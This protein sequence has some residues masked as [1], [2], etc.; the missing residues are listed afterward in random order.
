MFSSMH[1][2]TGVALLF[3]SLTLGLIA[4]ENDEFQEKGK[5]KGKGKGKSEIVQVDLSKLHPGIAQYIRDQIGQ[6]YKG[7]DEM[8]K[9]K[10]KG[11]GEAK[12]TPEPEPKKKAESKGKG[13]GKLISLADAISIGERSGTVIKA[14]RRGEAADATFK[15]EVL[16]S[17]GA[18]T[19][20]SLDANGRVI[21]DAQKKGDEKGKK[22]KGKGNQDG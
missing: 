18:K 7:K 22:G 14:E 1:R 9:G 10:G 4:A 21:Q 3:A 16:G 11:K 5:G 2:L 17:D 6:D 20:I 19:R 8:K 12:S 15:L 13:K